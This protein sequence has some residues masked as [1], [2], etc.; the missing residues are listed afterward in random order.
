[1]YFILLN[2]SEKSLLQIIT[3]IHTVH[4][5]LWYFKLKDCSKRHHYA[6]SNGC[7]L[8]ENFWM[9]FGLYKRGRYYNLEVQQTGCFKK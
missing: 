9:I 8:A 6:W 5:L 1:M 4:E 2:K 7:E 3:L